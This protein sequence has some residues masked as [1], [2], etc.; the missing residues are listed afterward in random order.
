MNHPKNSLRLLWGAMFAVFGM[1][2]MAQMPVP[3]LDSDSSASIPLEIWDI[4]APLLHSALEC[5][6]RLNPDDPRLR[7]I[8]PENKLNEWHLVP[9]RRF[10][11]FGLP[12]H[13]FR[14][15]IP[16][17]E[18]AVYTTVLEAPEGLRDK[19]QGQ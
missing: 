5:R 7:P 11:V 4:A 14:L 19:G 9:P 16:S 17:A 13:D 3:L 8:L 15:W 18:Q 12:V 6:Q 10:T 1:V 2:S